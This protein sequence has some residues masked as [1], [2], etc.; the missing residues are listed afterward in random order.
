M[1]TRLLNHTHRRAAVAHP[2]EGKD[3][4]MALGSV[5]LA[6]LLV[7]AAALR[8]ELA[9]HIAL[10][11]DVRALPGRFDPMTTGTP[12][13]AGPTLTVALAIVENEAFGA[14]RPAA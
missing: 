4:G 14:A 9:F 1:C 8:H 13:T 2:F 6:G 10:A 3:P 12:I 5:P 11:P 7:L